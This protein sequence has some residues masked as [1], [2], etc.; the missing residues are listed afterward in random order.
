MTTFLASST[1]GLS[2]A[3]PSFSVPIWG[4]GRAK[5]P[6]A[7]AP[8][9]KRAPRILLEEPA[10]LILD[11]FQFPRQKLRVI[12]ARM[13]FR[14]HLAARAW[15]SSAAPERPFSSWVFHHRPC[16]AASGRP[17]H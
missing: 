3:P 1:L 17:W 8:K 11:G 13:F 16:C 6:P 5:I 9:T 12:P 10:C 15:P 7:P 14:E 4:R 2:P